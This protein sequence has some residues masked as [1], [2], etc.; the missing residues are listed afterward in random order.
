M[1]ETEAFVETR[2]D[3]HNCILTFGLQPTRVT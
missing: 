1:S 2:C 3:G